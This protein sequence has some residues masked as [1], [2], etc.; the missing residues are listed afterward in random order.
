MNYAGGLINLGAYSGRVGT[1]ISNLRE[2]NRRVLITPGTRRTKK[3]GPFGPIFPVPMPQP[4]FGYAL[5]SP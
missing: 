1:W 5:I 2:L 4:R 3:I